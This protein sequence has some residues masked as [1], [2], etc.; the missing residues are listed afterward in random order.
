MGL[1]DLD[2]FV[3]GLMILPIAL[4]L[5]LSGPV[6]IVSY[7]AWRWALSRIASQKG[8]APARAL[9]VSCLIL[10][11]LPPVYAFGFVLGV[12]P[13]AALVLMQLAVTVAGAVPLVHAAFRD[14]SIAEASSDSKLR[15]SLASVP[16]AA[17]RQ[18]LILVTAREHAYPRFAGAT[19]RRALRNAL[20][21]L[22]ALATAEWVL[23]LRSG[24]T[25]A[26]TGFHD[27]SG[28]DGGTRGGQR[29]KELA[30]DRDS[31]LPTTDN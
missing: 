18:G 12:A 17:G 7:A 30:L 9:S 13:T 10:T 21:V 23:F 2:G 14:Q 1:D 11:A 8:T 31:A 28:L 20:V 29:P 24:H 27:A 4:T 19:R 5:V 22:A 6:T 15:E 3:M 25:A 26:Q 16:Y